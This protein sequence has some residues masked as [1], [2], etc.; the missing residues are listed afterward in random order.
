MDTP[1]I[2]LTFFPGECKIYQDIFQD[3]LTKSIRFLFVS[4]FFFQKITLQLPACAGK[5][6][7]LRFGIP[8]QAMPVCLFFHRISL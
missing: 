6:F 2:I 1:V 7:L 5:G 3:F 8:S 4:R